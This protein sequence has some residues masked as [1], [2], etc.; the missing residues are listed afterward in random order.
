[1]YRL[2]DSVTRSTPSTDSG[3]INPLV[4]L[5]SFRAL[6][7]IDVGLVGQR[8][9]PHE[10]QATFEAN[11]A[12]P[13]HQPD[14]GDESHVPES[15]RPCSVES[16]CGVVAVSP[17]PPG[18]SFQPLE[19]SLW[20]SRPGDAVSGGLSRNR[21]LAPTGGAPVV[22]T[23]SKEKRSKKKAPTLGGDR[24]KKKAKTL[25]VRKYGACFRCSAYKEEVGVTPPESS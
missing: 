1:M 21:A 12:D 5:K 18:V 23:A 2:S 16:S 7:A 9:D 17:E 25:R 13:A 22:R 3:C 6:G 4:L 24:K 19:D 11:E 8:E 20:S 14:L 15:G 10:L